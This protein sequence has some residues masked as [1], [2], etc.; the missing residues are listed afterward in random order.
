M[1][2]VLEIS[3]SHTML[4]V[5]EYVPHLWNPSVEYGKQQGT[6]FRRD[7]LLNGSALHQ[8]LYVYIQTLKCL[9][10]LHGVDVPAETQDEQF[11]IRF[12]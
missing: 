4:Y 7:Q 11:E 10:L 5:Q 3:L 12:Q 8:S 6:H 9:K 1:D 2:H